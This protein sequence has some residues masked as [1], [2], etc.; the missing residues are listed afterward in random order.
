MSAD[1]SISAVQLLVKRTVSFP[2]L[3]VVERSVTS[4]FVLIQPPRPKELIALPKVERKIA[5]WKARF[6]GVE[7][8]PA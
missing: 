3:D 5:E 4:S 8:H 7:S 2:M 6:L 1:F